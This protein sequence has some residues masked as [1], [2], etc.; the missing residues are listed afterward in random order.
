M[1][2]GCA[3]CYGEDV[4][5][6]MDHV[7]KHARESDRVVDHSHFGVSVRVCGECGQRF[8]MIFAEYVDWVRSED[9][10]YF[11]V[12]PVTENEAVQVVAAGAGISLDALGKLGHGRRRMS[13]EWPSGEPKTVSWRSGWFSVRPG[14]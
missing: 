6:A 8:V 7:L 14:D 9:P 11:D 12:V 13:S 10:Q 1:E 2:F 5:T 3:A 4:E